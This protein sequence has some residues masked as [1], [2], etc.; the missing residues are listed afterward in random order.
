MKAKGADWK[1][2]WNSVLKMV[3]KYAERGPFFLNPDEVVVRNII[4]G[5]A[6]NK[7]EYG[8]AYCPCR[9]VEGSPEKDK[10]NICPCRMHK[11]EIARQGI[12]ECGLFVSQAYLNKRRK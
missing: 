2:T 1:K 7:M 4:S 5:L 9:Q 10:E 3:T 6:K 11:E 12:C 8:Y